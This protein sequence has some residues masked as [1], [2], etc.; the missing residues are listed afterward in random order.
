MVASGPWLQVAVRLSCT[1]MLL[2]LPDLHMNLPIMASTAVLHQRV[3]PTSMQRRFVS[4]F[5]QG[6]VTAHL[7][8]LLVD[9][10]IRPAPRPDGKILIIGGGIANF[11]N[12]AATFKGIIK[13]LQG[14][15]AGL[16]AHGVSP[17]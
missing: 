12:V 15:K 2:Q 13:A 9:L 11:T 3:K 1:Q 16:I 7:C 17:L 4:L 8:M 14:A 5:L 6:C 10:I